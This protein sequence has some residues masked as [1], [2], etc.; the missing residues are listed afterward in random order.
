MCSAETFLGTGCRHR[1]A[2]AARP[3]TVKVV[4]RDVPPGTSAVQAIHDENGNRELDHGAFG[5]PREGMGFSRDAPMRMGPPKFSDAAVE[6]P[7]VGGTLR[8]SMRYFR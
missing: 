4:L 1:A 7:E 8:L 2:A 6:V 5:P 3:G